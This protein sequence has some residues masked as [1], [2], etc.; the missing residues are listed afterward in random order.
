MTLTEAQKTTFIEAIWSYYAQHARSGLPWRQPELDGQFDPY[1]ILVSELMLQQT[2]VTR[3]VPKYNEFLQIFPTV[4]KLAA[5]ELSG[6]LRA[7][8]GL[9]YNRRVK[10]LWLAAQQIAADGWPADLTKLSG[11]GVN[12]AGAIRA[13]AFNEPAVFV[14]TNIRTVYIHHFAHDQHDVSDAFIRDLLSQTLKFLTDKGKEQPDKKSHLFAG[15]MRKNAVLS[16]EP[17]DFYWALMDYGTYLKAERG[18]LNNQS[19]QYSKQS[20]FVGSKRQI[21]GAVIRALTGTPHT[22]NELADSIADDRLAGVLEDLT[23][24][25]LIQKR[26]NLY[27]L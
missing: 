16:H 22:F 2:Q 14:E 7:W 6:V 8:Q 19:K 12:T 26:H 21:R 24:E 18:S 25:G 3:V 17:R 27:S 4:E 1:K 20:A 13:Y 5:A 23:N 11:V 10:Y 15:A 9:G